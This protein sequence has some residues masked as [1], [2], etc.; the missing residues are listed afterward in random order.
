MWPAWLG[1]GPAVEGRWCG[2]RAALPAVL[3]MSA[4]DIRVGGE[5]GAVHLPLP[6]S[7]PSAFITSVPAGPATQCPRSCE[8]LFWASPIGDGGTKGGAT[9]RFRSERQC[10]PEWL[11]TAFPSRRDREFESV[12]LQR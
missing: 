8:R 5:R 10:L 9:Y 12:F 6:V 1:E 2:A 3:G 11:P 7:R 4:E